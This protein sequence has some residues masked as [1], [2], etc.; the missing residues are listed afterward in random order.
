[1]F[2]VNEAARPGERDT[3]GGRTTIGR[4]AGTSLDKYRRL[5][6][7]QKTILIVDD[8]RDLSF[9][10]SEMLEQHNYDV[11]TAET[12]EEAYEKLT[13]NC[14]QLILL[15]INL[16]DGNGYEVCREL[17][18]NSQ[19]PVI[20]ASA[21]DTENDRITGYE[22]GGDDYLPKPYS[23]KELLAHVRALMRR[24]YG[25]E[26]AEEAET[27]GDISVN[28]VQR[29]V[30]K[31]GVA[32]NLALREFDLLEYLLRNKNRAVTKE[33]IMG[34][35]WGA[36]TEAEPSTISV[37]MRWLREKLETN[38]SEPRYFKTVRGVGYMLDTGK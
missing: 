16:P 8:D 4:T 32:V 26:D 36:F 3:V 30:T 2:N 21:R 6:M 11:I 20:F 34:N 14:C 1:M 22:A 35:V 19:L 27:F 9:I 5:R 38:P 23:M 7:N 15:D 37:H 25:A 31:N 18:K 17:R 29:T 28:F 13:A 24:C 12:V 10:I 33:E